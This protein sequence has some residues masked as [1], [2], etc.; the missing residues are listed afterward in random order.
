MPK[1]L[2]H[3]SPLAGILLYL[4][5][6]Q[7]SEWM[8]GRARQLAASTFYLQWLCADR[9]CADR[10][11]RSQLNVSN[12]RV[13]SRQCCL[14][15]R[16]TYS[17]KSIFVGCRKVCVCWGGGGCA[18]T[19]TYSYLYNYNEGD[20]GNV[21]VQTSPTLVY[22]HKSLYVST[23]PKIVPPHQSFNS[24]SEFQLSVRVL[25]PHQSFNS[26]FS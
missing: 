9:L 22:H 23:C 6:P 10:L 19:R 18:G 16:W 4:N 3:L 21:Q 11:C 2:L 15:C 8:W 12:A 25:T 14:G 24:P 5:L 7:A 1:Q 20:F 17:S 13:S 26:P